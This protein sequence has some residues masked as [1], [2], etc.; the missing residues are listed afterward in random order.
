MD[1]NIEAE[2]AEVKASVSKKE[3]KSKNSAEDDEDD[4]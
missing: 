2:N 4:E 1:E 3:K